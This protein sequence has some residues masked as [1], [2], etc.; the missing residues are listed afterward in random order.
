VTANARRPN[1]GRPALRIVL[2]LP[3]YLPETSGGAEHQSRRFAQALARR[4]AT[5]T[6]LAPRLQGGTPALETEGPVSVRRFRLPISAD[7]TSIRSP[8]G[9]SASAP[10]CGGTDEVTT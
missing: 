3:A 7:D 6:L 2:V 4:G 5:V 1:I 9:A 10:G 8:G